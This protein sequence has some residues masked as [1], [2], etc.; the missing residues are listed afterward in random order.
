ML[1]D[2][3][4]VRTMCKHRR[5]GFLKDRV[6]MLPVTAKVADPMLDAL[7]LHKVRLSA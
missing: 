6:I 1:L 3:G 4:P 5:D 2:P 7:K